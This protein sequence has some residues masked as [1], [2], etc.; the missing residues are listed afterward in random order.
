MKMHSIRAAAF[1]LALLG[2]GRLWATPSLT[3]PLSFNGINGEYPGGSLIM[4]AAGNLYGTTGGN[5]AD[6][7]IGPY[8][9]VFEIPAKTHS[10]TDLATFGQYTGSNPE[11]LTEDASG[12]MYGILTNAADSE[13]GPGVIFEVSGA[14]HSFSTLASV[15]S[16]DADLTSDSAGNLYGTTTTGGTNLVGSI[17]ELPVGSSVPVTLTS[18]NRSNGMYP[19]AAGLLLGWGG[20]IYGTT[21]AGGFYDAGTIFKFNT[22]T[23]TIST[24]A[25]FNVCDG[26]FPRTTL[27]ADGSGNLYGTTSQGGDFNV[28]TIF[29][30]NTST[31]VLSDLASFDV[32]DGS[33]PYAGLIADAAGNLYGTTSSGGAYGDGTVFELP[34][35]SSTPLTLF[36]FNGE[37]GAN[38]F[39]ELMADKKG[40]FFGTT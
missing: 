26:Q 36:S 2:T 20:Y 1:T 23:N 38:P 3:M 8:G 24:L 10:I 15:T 22:Q 30:W 34:A 9:S 27:I 40:N 19:Q 18:F 17:Y 37:D 6:S 25:Q 12:N 32:T 14:P 11:G 29:E 16:P 33:F 39:C 31:N 7:G 13:T 5:E 4:D 21:A 28:G 35:G